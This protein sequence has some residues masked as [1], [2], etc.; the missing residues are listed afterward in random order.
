[1]RPHASS[2]SRGVRERAVWLV[3][4]IAVLAVL[5]SVLAVGFTSAAG[6]ASGGGAVQIYGIPGNGGGASPVLFT[7]AI[8]DFGRALRQ[9]ANGSANKNGSDVKFNLRQ[10]TFVGNGTALF[11]KLNNPAPMSFNTSTC[12]GAFTASAPMPL[13]SGTGK[14]AGIG[15]SLN[16][17]VTFAFV[18]PR[19]KSGKHK[20]QCNGNAKPLAQMGTISGGGMV[21]LG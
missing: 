4:P 7:G 8:G 12:S 9:N 2:D 17:R 16:V 15:G 19:F 3:K 6:A 5:A 10:G 14:Y 13:G 11:R 20:G 1:M 21:S 18:A